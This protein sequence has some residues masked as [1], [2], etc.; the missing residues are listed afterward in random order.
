MERSVWTQPLSASQNLFCPWSCDNPLKTF[1][2]DK[3]I[4]GNQRLFL[5]RIWLGSGQICARFDR[6]WGGLENLAHNISGLL[7]AL[8]HSGP[9]KVDDGE[10]EEP[11][12]QRLMGKRQPDRDN[13]EERRHAQSNL[14]HRD[15]SDD[16]RAVRKRRRG[17]GA[18]R[19][20]SLNEGERDDRIG[21][22][23][24]VELRRCRVVEHRWQPARLERFARNEA[25]PH[26]R[27][28]VVDE[29]GAEAR[30]QGAEADLAEHRRSEQAGGNQEPPAGRR[31]RARPLAKPGGGVDQRAERGRGDH[32]VDRQAL[33][34]Y[35]GSLAQARRHHPPTD[36]RL[37]RQQAG[38]DGDLPPKRAFELSLPPEPQTW[39]DK[40]RTDEPREQPMAPFPPEDG[41]EAV[42]RHVRIE[43]RELRDL[44]ITVELGLP[45]RAAHW[46]NH[47][48]DRLPL[49]DRETRLGQTGRAADQNHKEDQT[50]HRD[51]PE[52]N[53]GG[54][55][56]ARG[57][58]GGGRAVGQ[59]HRIGTSAFLK[60]EPRLLAQTGPRRNAR[61]D[62][63]VSRS[64]LD[65]QAAIEMPGRMAKNREDHE[66]RDEK[67]G[68]RN[69][70]V[71]ADDDR[72]SQHR[73]RIGQNR[74]HAGGHRGHEIHLAIDDERWGDGGDRKDEESN[75]RA[76]PVADQKERHSVRGGEDFGEQLRHG[77]NVGAVEHQENE[78][79]EV[80]PDD[81]GEETDKR[82]PPKLLPLSA[83][84]RPENR[85]P[86]Q[87]FAAFQT[88]RN[89][90]CAR[91]AEWRKQRKTHDKRIGEIGIV[92]RERRPDNQEAADRIDGAE[93][94]AVS[95]RPSKVLQPLGDAL[96]DIGNLDLADLEWRRPADVGG[97]LIRG[98]RPRANHNGHQIA[99]LV[100]ASSRA[101]GEWTTFRAGDQQCGTRHFAASHEATHRNAAGAS[102]NCAE[103]HCRVARAVA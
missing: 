70:K 86:G 58:A 56:E 80:E 90:V 43:R 96:D 82:Q 71:G 88:A 26:E 13:R 27:P 78:D 57:L 74:A 62:R 54:S 75:D 6:F 83:P 8:L 55:I 25:R 60:L 45:F 101:H 15:R 100:A 94:H 36:D 17:R 69:R 29:A 1:V 39:E 89:L 35:F 84:D 7:T 63:D 93:E 77:R 85:R 22:R 103:N 72:P 12:G 50:G 5:G 95:G 16:E 91:R 30:D 48:G 42:D 76:Q 31:A 32:K 97:L 20:E 81:Q 52:P 37:E 79:R 14:K 21:E 102:R 53:S 4:K 11:E 24:M 47:P 87:R 92:Q 3:G 9:A 68:E 2:S 19:G 33:L 66:E 28:G 64:L 10:A 34:R 41:L 44:L 18:N 67:G 73:A 38:G 46:R 49:G 51:Q 23:A 98:R 40:S 59:G 65:D 61:R 99:P